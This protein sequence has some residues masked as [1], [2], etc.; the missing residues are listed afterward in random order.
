[1]KQHDSSLSG[2]E[3]KITCVENGFI[4]KHSY[5]LSEKVQVFSTF[6]EVI[7]EIAFIFNCRGIG[8]NLD[9]RSSLTH[10]KDYTDIRQGDPGDEMECG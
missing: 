8:E 6:T 10:I 2:K 3:V 1:M 9:V 7:N 4:I 5:L